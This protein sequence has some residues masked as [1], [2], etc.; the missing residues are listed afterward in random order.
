MSVLIFNHGGGASDI[1]IRVVG[2]TV[3]P[4]GVA[5]ML[6]CNT[7]VQASKWTFSVAA[8]SSPAVG[9]LWMQTDA[10]STRTISILKRNGAIVNLVRVKQWNGTSW[11]V[12]LAYYHN[13]TSWTQVSV[14]FDPH[15]DMTYTGTMTIVD[16]GNGDWHVDF[17][18]SGTLRF[19]ADPGPIDKF[20]VGGGAG[21]G[22]YG[23]GGGGY[24]AIFNGETVAINTDYAIVIGAGGAGAADQTVD[25]NNGGTTSGMGHTA[26]GGLAGKSWASGY[27]GNG[28]S[29]GGGG[30][31]NAVGAVGGSDGSN[32]VTSNTGAIGGTG[33]HTTTRKF[34]D[35]TGTLFAGGGGGYGPGG[36]GAGGPGG[37]GA[38]LAAGTVNTGGGGG[39]RAAGGSGIFCIRNHRAA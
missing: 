9:D 1:A 37:G 18:T 5:G 14:I 6:W 30:S 10:S 11:A 22:G 4:T 39:A 27:G 34:G 20:L 21:G 24:A 15:T 25:G 13:G 8:P 36:Q 28:G 3:Q 33:Q 2:G 17:K 35:A 12:K 7:N 19:L 16:D 29:G 31:G 38:G 23:G 32:G 26:P